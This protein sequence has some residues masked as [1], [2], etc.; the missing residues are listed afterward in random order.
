MKVLLVSK[1]MVSAAYRQKAIE[2]ARLPDLELTVV[3]PPKW[4]EPGVGDLPLE[5]GADAGYRLVVAPIWFNGRHHLHLFPTLGRIVREVRPDVL[6]ADDESFNLVT[7]HAL[8][9]GGRAGAC[10]VFFNWANIYRRYPPPFSWFERFTFRRAA[11]GVAGNVAAKEI[12]KRRGYRGP[13]AVIPQFGVDPDLFRPAA[14][15]SADFTVGFLGRIVPAKGLDVLLRAVAGLDAQV[16]V[17]V[18]GRGQDEGR[19]R[20]LAASLGIADRVEFRPPVPTPEVPAVLAPIACLAVPSLTTPT[21]K[22]QFGRVIIE[23]MA[24]GVPVVGSD[25][26]EI[27]NVIGDAGIVVEEGNAEALRAAL[28]RLSED[29]ALRADLAR[30]GRERV[31]D[32]F[33]HRRIAERYAEVY[34]AAWRGEG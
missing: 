4:R 13:I 28:R 3:V 12:L 11:A 8:R 18:V 19:M 23:A 9:I 34:R 14:R 27:P 1:A 24:C 26:G 5:R 29:P 30:R 16:R 25:S 15:Q 7:A 32:L 31:L 21:W 2:L 6:H 20:A 17:L 10:G 22:E 33:T